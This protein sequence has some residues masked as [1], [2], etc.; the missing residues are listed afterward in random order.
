MRGLPAAHH[1]VCVHSTWHSAARTWTT[2]RAARSGRAVSCVAEWA[3]ALTCQGCE[4]CG[5]TREMGERERERVRTCDD[6][7]LYRE[8]PGFVS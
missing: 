6:W 5:A 2:R 7:D 3:E 8:G 1:V 4:T